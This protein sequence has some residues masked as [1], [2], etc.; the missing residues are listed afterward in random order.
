MRVENHNSSR[1]NKAIRVRS[2]EGT[3]V[4]NVDFAMNLT[5][6]PGKDPGTTVTICREN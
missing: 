2:H 6:R 4:Y 5:V 1:S 3:D